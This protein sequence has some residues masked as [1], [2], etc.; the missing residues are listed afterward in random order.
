MTTLLLIRHA[1]TLWHAENRYAGSSD[2]G[3]S[4]AGVAQAGMLA[5]HAD[6]IRPGKLITSD[7]TRSVRTAAPLAA[8]LGITA[9]P[10]RRL[11][12]VDFGE[13]EGLTRQEMR[14]RFPAELDG[15]L[16]TPASTP[17][18]GGEPGHLA[19]TRAMAAIEAA[20]AGQ[21]TVL[22]VGHATLI[23]LVVCHLL[24]IDLDRYRSVFPVL[25]NLHLSTLHRDA[26]GTALLG[27]NVGLDTAAAVDTAGGSAPAAAAPSRSAGVPPPGQEHPHRAAGE[28][29]GT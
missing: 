25:G 28:E 18:P 9:M 10:D 22:Y 20:C 26:S 6:T 19:V 27:F 23:R 12:E 4:P 3:L 16:A 21:D 17:L 15:F 29:G 2:I 8:A 7:L 13:G 1:Q 24:G 5:E 11:R 14:A